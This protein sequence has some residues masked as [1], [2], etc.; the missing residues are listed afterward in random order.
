M[1]SIFRNLLQC[2][3]ILVKDKAEVLMEVERLQTIKDELSTEVASLHTQLEQER[4]KVRQLTAE[5]KNKVS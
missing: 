5:N 2:N 1:E 4:S 3:V